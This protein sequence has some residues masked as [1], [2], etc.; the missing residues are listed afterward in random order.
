MNLYFA[1]ANLSWLEGFLDY[2]C[3]F[4][5]LQDGTRRIYDSSDLL[6]LWSLHSSGL[7]YQNFSCPDR[8]HPG[9]E[10]QVR[11]CK[12]N[13]YSISPTNAASRV[14]KK[15]VR[16]LKL[17]R[18]LAAV[19]ILICETAST[20]GKSDTSRFPDCGVANISWLMGCFV[21]KCMFGL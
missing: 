13:I 18:R 3:T 7:R 12:P 6:M 17:D 5:T 14:I 16:T 10:S 15:I 19:T 9:N 21:Y 1:V 4:G 11:V 2:K 20:F 8:R